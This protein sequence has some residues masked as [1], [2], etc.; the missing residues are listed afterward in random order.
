[1]FFLFSDYINLFK[2]YDQKNL[3]SLTF[4]Q[5]LELDA[6]TNETDSQRDRRHSRIKRFVSL[7]DT[8]N[9]ELFSLS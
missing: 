7:S 2:E 8:K 1:M 3:G 4:D 6:D 5:L 9:G